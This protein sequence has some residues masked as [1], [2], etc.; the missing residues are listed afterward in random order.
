MPVMI[1][2]DPDRGDR[3]AIAAPY[4][5]N[6]LIKTIPGS[7]WSRQHERWSVPL[8]WTACVACRSV[9]G[10]DMEIGHLLA[11]WAIA[12]KEHRIIPAMALRDAMDAAGDQDLYGHQRSGVQF[13]TTVERGLLTD[14]PGCVSGDAQ[15]IV[16]RGGGAR[17]ITL[18]DLY[19]KFNSAGLGSNSQW[20]AD[21]PTRTVSMWE[22]GSL[23]LNTV[24]AVT[25]T[26][27]QSVVR[28]TLA[29]GRTVV[30]TPDHLLATDCS[31]WAEAS[32]LRPGSSVMVNGVPEC[33]RCGGGEQVVESPAAKHAGY[34]RPCIYKYMRDNRARWGDSSG[35]TITRDGYVQLAGYWD[36][37]NSDS[38]G[39]LLEHVLVM[40]VQLG[41]GLR[42]DEIVHHRDH[43][44]RNNSLDNLELLTRG[45]HSR[46]HALED[47][48]K[49]RLHGSS[50]SRGEVWFRAH[51]D[52]VVSVETAGEVDVYDISM[53]AP[54][55]SFV[56]DGVVVHNCGKTATAIR[57][58]KT[59]YD[60]GEDVFPALIVAPN[61]VKR[62][63]AREFAHWW[64]DPSVVVVDGTAAQRR[65]QIESDSS[66]VI[67]NWEALRTH[68]RL[69]PY[70]S[71]ALKRCAACGGSG[72]VRES[73]CQ[74]HDRELNAIDFN[75]VIADE[76]HRGKNAKSLQTLALRGATGNARFRW[77]L[78]G[79]PIANDPTELW[80]ILNWL[81]PQEWPSRTKWVERLVAYTYN[82]WGGMEVGGIRPD[83]EAEFRA[84]VDPRMRRMTK[85][86]VL[87]F[88]PPRVF[89]RRDVPMH[90]KQEKAYRQMA[91]EMVARLDSGILLSSN[92]MVQTGRLTQFAS[93]YG[94]IEN[95][96]G[97]QERLV[98][99]EPSNKVAAFLDDLDDFGDQ[100][101]A[102]F[103]ESRQL[104]ELLS[105][106]LL[107][108]GV[109]HGLV[110]G[111]QS[112]DERQHAIESFQSGD[113]RLVLCTI[114]AGGVGIT[115]TRASVAVFLQRSWSNVDMEQAYNRCHRIGSE[116]H[117]SVT[118]IDYVTPGTV[119]EGQIW[120]LNRKGDLMQQIV[121]DAD[122]LRKIL[123]GGTG[124]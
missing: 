82:V 96:G 83:A 69:A 63:W 58:L 105:A 37:P 111:A 34:C 21:I 116:Q 39:R 80:S 119:E 16:N 92:P 48:I 70:G 26:G 73:A 117:A 66:V 89:E 15:I 53:Q 115:L 56:A 93:A 1:E 72:A 78:T 46:K 45:E 57:A 67:V 30:C 41:R 99:G 14:E 50:G 124:E 71:T 75:T 108:K 55:H 24:T 49:D 28:V 4:H 31:T 8:A 33:K 5:F 77:A 109:R 51:P 106:A 102:V 120:A 40:S 38:R 121:R 74:V 68:S 6:D 54:A 79:T 62:T 11:A 18:R 114:K 25:A 17:R 112:G 104:I 101:I 100:S 123:N 32:A 76:A 59:L 110:T 65:K 23:G 122:L 43:D 61:T 107:K 19:K 103:A 42:P 87:P 44:K 12:E 10:P 85:E 90:P 52:T 88:L 86:A 84:T 97:P 113:T 2:R 47:V 91:E 9:F 81:D 13:L 118:F 35:S 95:A 64:P 22:D 98:L 20:R 7:S 29:S 36:H 94:D 60:R 3:I 27:V